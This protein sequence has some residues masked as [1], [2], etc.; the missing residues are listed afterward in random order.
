MKSTQAMLLLATLP[1]GAQA[2]VVLYGEIQGALGRHSRSVSSANNSVQDTG[3]HIG[4]KGSEDLASGRKALWQVESRIHLDGSAAAKSGFASRESFLGLQDPAFGTIHLGHLNS[5]VKNLHSLDQWKYAGNMRGGEDS[6]GVNG[7][8]L[9]SNQKK[10]LRHALRYDAPPLAGLSSSLAY[11]FG[12]GHGTDSADEKDH[13]ASSIVSLGLKY[14]KGPGFISYGYE[15][16]ARPDGLAMISGKL[17]RAA[18]SG[19]S[20]HA[21]SIHYVETGY[22]DEQL[23]LGVGFQRAQG[24][25]WSD[26]LSGSSKSNY[27]TDDAPLSAAQARLITRQIALSSAYTMGAFTPKLSIAKGWN[28]SRAGGSMA[29]SGYR[30]VIAGVDYRL[31][32]RTVSGLSSGHLWL[33][34]NAHS[35]LN[36][37]AATFGSLQLNLAHKF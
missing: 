14:Q 8:V 16:E 5:A 31:S 17:K 19:G 21:A 33:E 32:K 2:E 28:Q 12:A 27:G 29:S 30:Q 20:V 15:R 4:F 24:Y 11:A 9:F 7:L 1:L 25:D 13:Q 37:Q 18:Q 26:R 23:L 22:K 34:R 36:Q 10:T 6:Q 3:S 35:A